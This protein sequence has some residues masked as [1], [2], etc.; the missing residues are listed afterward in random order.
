MFENDG[1]H[2][3]HIVA[4][5]A[6]EKHGVPVGIPCFTI[7]PGSSGAVGTLAGLCNGRV[8]RAGYVGTPSPMA[9]KRPYS[10]S[11]PKR[12]GWKKK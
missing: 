5:H 9:V 12:Q 11:R 2:I 3:R 8:M 4:D 1:K 7:Y 6:C 10:D